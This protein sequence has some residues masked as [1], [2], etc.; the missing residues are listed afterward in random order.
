MQTEYGYYKFPEVPAQS[1]SPLSMVKSK[2]RVTY[3]HTATNATKI[4]MKKKRGPPGETIAYA[5]GPWV[6]CQDWSCMYT[7]KATRHEDRQWLWYEMK[8]STTRSQDE[9]AKLSLKLNECEYKSKMGSVTE[10]RYACFIKEHISFHLIALAC[11]S[12]FNNNHDILF[13]QR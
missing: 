8:T 9:I 4:K 11:N 7:G 12:H 13:W 5:C 10:K 6:L 3:N 1:S 2:Q